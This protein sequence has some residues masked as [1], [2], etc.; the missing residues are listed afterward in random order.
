MI[1][2]VASPACFAKDGSGAVPPAPLLRH[3]RACRNVVLPDGRVRLHLGHTPAGWIT[4]DV[5]AELLARGAR[6]A[7]DGGAILDDPARLQP[8]AA[9][10]AGAGLFRWRGEAFD[11]RGT[12]DGPVLTVLDRGALPVFGIEAV[13]VHLN[14]L[15]RRGSETLLWVARRSADKPLD[16]GK[17]D[18]LVGG[19]VPAGLSPEAAL[20]KESAEE[21]GLPADLA[22]QARHVATIAYVMRRPEGLRRDR[23]HCFDLELPE[24]F[25]PRAADG[26]VECFALRPI[27]EVLQR[28]RQT[29]DFKFN[30]N[31]VLIDL[32]LRL[33]MIVGAEA[34]EL[35]AAIDA[36]EPV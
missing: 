28:V 17:L 9:E 30:V 18:H 11:V 1:P 26:E 33:G 7:P 35:R 13:G 29:D 31:L 10:L 25:Q 22:R 2:D 4:P 5:G 36:D 34:A 14:G 21:A 8:I 3:I 20:L 23:L 19:G 12:A 27:Q 24:S 15:V 16:P 32:F 6:P